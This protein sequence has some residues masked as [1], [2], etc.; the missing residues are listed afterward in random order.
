MSVGTEIRRRRKALKLTLED[1]AHRLD[2][3]TGNLSRVE[4]GQ[5]GASE[6]MLHKIAHV[7][8]C[9][10]ADLFA[11]TA[12]SNV[13]QTPIGSRRI[14]VVSYVRA[15]HM[16]EAV[17]PYPVGDAEEWILTDQ[18]ELS[19]GAFALRIRGDS[20]LPEFREGDTVII[21]PAIAPLPGDYVVAKNG[22]NEATF[23]KYRPR[24]INEHGNPV[25]EL[26]PLNDDYPSM[27]SD[28]TPIRIIGTMIEHRRYRKK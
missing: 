9:T 26:V 16:A 18:L 11:G 21:D 12:P 1:M 2:S 28:R 19:A 7:L 20:M 13:T 17:D 5:Q 8:G 4:R 14:P 23:K 6:A 27:R 25:F 15:G 22:D 3:D 10:V 24:G